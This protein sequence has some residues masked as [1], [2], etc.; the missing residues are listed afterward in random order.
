MMSAVYR[1]GRHLGICQG[2]EASP[3]KIGSELLGIDTFEMP[4]VGGQSHRKFVQDWFR[5]CAL[6]TGLTEGANKRVGKEAAEWAREDPKSE[7][8]WLIYG[9]VRLL[10]GEYLQA[11]EIYAK[12]LENLPQ[13]ARL[14]LGQGEAYR[15]AGNYHQALRN[16][17]KSIRFAAMP[18][19]FLTSGLANL[20]LGQLSDAAAHFEAATNHMTELPLAWAL[21]G[22]C[23]P[24]RK[25]ECWKNA[26]E[27]HEAIGREY[28]F[29]DPAFPMHSLTRSVLEGKCEPIHRACYVV[30]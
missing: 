3:V 19:A 24:E 11:L 26:R 15:L 13:C 4:T 14:Y 6:R 16:Y 5:Y 12:A 10:S 23:A 1:V 18:M 9:A 29:H 28:F 20:K 22:N 27:V 7:F 2:K 25:E 8:A 17:A 21:L 30:L